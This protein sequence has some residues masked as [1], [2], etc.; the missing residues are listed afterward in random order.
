MPNLNNTGNINI[1]V[2]LKILIKFTIKITNIF[3]FIELL[4]YLTEISIDKKMPEKIAINIKL[5][6]SNF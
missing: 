3:Y 1:Y 4:L 5:R 6:I 2:I